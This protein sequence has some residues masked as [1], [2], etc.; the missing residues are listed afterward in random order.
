MLTHRNLDRQRVALPG[1][2]PVPA[3]D[4]LAHRRAAVPR[5]R[6]DRR[7]CRPCGT[8][9][10]R[11]CCRRSTRRS[12]LDLIERHG[13]TG[14]LLVPTML[15]ALNEEQLARPRDVVEPEGD[16]PRR[17]AGRD[18]DAAP[19]P[20]RLPDDRA[21]RDVRHDR[22]GADRDDVP[23]RG[24]AARHAA[25]PLVRPARGRR[26]DP[27]RRH[28]RRTRCRRRGRRGRDPRR[29]RDGRLLEQARAD[30]GRARRR[31]VPLGRP[32]LPR[33]RGLRVPRRPGQGHD[34]ERR[35]ER[36]QHRGRGRAV[37]PSRGA[38]GRGVRRARPAVGRGRLRRRDPAQRGHRARADRALPASDRRLQGAEADRAAHRAAAE[39]RRR[40]GAQARAARAVLGRACESRVGGT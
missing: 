16:L 18:R 22:D 33:R 6:L 35:R 32:R 13:V 14:T 7:A 11:S 9:A 27:H 1:L 8:A 31:L 26:R 2:L 29:Q 17:L 20:Q 40:Q 15:A 5:R 25:R 39:V 37:P 19:R 4:V 28:R 36:V 3:R 24:A 10:V 23:R 38:R 12:A 21:A 30:R 34:R